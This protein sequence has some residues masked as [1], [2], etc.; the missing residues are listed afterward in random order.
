MAR[1]PKMAR[2]KIPLAC[3]IHCSPNFY[4]SFAR[5]AS[6][7]CEQYIYIYAHIWPGRD[8]L[9]ITVSAGKHFY[10]DRERYEMLTGYL[11]SGRRPGG[12]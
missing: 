5:P 2:R 7:Y 6:P 3:G 12:D 1:V 8:Y 4:I 9:S 10:T 11:S